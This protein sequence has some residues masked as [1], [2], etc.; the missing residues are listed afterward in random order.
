MLL[1]RSLTHSLTQSLTQLLADLFVCSLN[2]S[3]SPSLITP[4][5]VSS[6]AHSL[7][8]NQPLACTL[9]PSLSPSFACAPNRSLAHSLVYWLTLNQSSQSLTHSLTHSHTHSPAVLGQCEDVASVFDAGH[10]VHVLV[11]RGKDLVLET[12]YRLTALVSYHTSASSRLT[13]SHA[14]TASALHHWLC[15]GKQTGKPLIQSQ[16]GCG[17]E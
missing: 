6:L 15:P 1:T 4:T 14:V 7:I 8:L 16:T 10:A 9:P 11:A 3:N 5:L 17:D 13:R 2:R 12:D